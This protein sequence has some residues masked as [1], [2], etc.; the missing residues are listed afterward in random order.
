LFLGR[1]AQAILPIPTHFSVA[2]SVTFVHPAKGT[3]GVWT[4]SKT[5]NCKWRPDHQSYA[6]IWRIQRKSW[7]DLP[8]RFRLRYCFVFNN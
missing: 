3:F 5:C 1:I 2:R 6:A 4:P 7:V 8:Q